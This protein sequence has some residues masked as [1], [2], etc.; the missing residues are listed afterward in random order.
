M[1]FKIEPEWLNKWHV[2]P[3]LYHWNRGAKA[4]IHWVGP[5]DGLGNPFDRKRIRAIIMHGAGTAAARVYVDGRFVTEGTLVATQDPDRPRRL[6]LPRGSTGYSIR[7]EL[8]GYFEM[9]SLNVEFSLLPG[10]LE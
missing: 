9:D 2:G 7:V 1:T 5:D 8:W 3:G 10:G 4:P 6:N